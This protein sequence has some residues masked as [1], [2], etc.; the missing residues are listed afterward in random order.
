MGDG[1]PQATL[2]AI[3]CKAWFGARNCSF[4]DLAKTNVMAVQVLSAKFPS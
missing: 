3:G 2:A 4:D 1:E